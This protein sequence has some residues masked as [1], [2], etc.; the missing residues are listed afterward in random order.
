MSQSYIDLEFENFVIISRWNPCVNMVILSVDKPNSV[1]IWDVEN[2]EKLYNFL[3]YQGSDRSTPSSNVDEIKSC[4]WNYNGTKVLVTWS[5]KLKIWS[6]SNLSDDINFDFKTDKAIF[7]KDDRI[8][9]IG[10]QK[11]SIG[12]K[13]A[14]FEM[15][16]IIFF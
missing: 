7:L 8:L 12:R 16:I 2:K 13:Y 5:Q 6:T 10:Q 11:N 3:A 9:V 14:L 15:V 1:I 4:E